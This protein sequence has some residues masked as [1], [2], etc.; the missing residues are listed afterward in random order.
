MYFDGADISQ[1]P[2]DIPVTAIFIEYIPYIEHMM[3]IISRNISALWKN[4]FIY[5]FV[6]VIPVPAFQQIDTAPAAP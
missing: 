5:F 2:S 3:H 1:P 4:C 6:F